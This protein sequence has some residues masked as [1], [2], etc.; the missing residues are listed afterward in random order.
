M[1]FVDV[2]NDVAFRKIF[3]NTN[4]TEIIISFLNAILNLPEGKKIIQVTI[5]NPYQLPQI[6]NL[7]SS[8]LSPHSMTTIQ[9]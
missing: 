8:I 6:K 9:F 4:K 7:K 2:K 1:K 3:G 5:E